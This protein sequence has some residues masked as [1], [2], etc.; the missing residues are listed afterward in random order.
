MPSLITC[1]RAFPCLR[2][3]T[4]NMLPWWTTS[5]LWFDMVRSH[6]SSFSFWDYFFLLSND[7]MMYQSGHSWMSCFVTYPLGTSMHLLLY[8]YEL[9]KQS[10]VE[11]VKHIKNTIMGIEPIAS[12]MQRFIASL[13]L[14]L[15]AYLIHYCFIQ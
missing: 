14:L 6:M 7:L 13:D 11:K 12:A 9:S 2:S 5:L 4:C 8:D 10:P 3:R 1:F 15:G